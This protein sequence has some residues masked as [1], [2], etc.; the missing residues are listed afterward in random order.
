MERWTL[1]WY[2]FLKPDHPAKVFVIMSS[3]VS[4]LRAWEFIMHY[5]REK[6]SP[7]AKKPMGYRH[8]DYGLSNGYNV[9]QLYGMSVVTWYLIWS[10]DLGLLSIRVVSEIYVITRFLPHSDVQL[11]ATLT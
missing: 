11:Y 2:G 9:Q 5:R 8:L 7:M 6:C 4:R 3:P 10:V 1:H